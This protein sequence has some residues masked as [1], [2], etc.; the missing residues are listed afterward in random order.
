MLKSQNIFIILA[1][2]VLV[3]AKSVKKDYDEE[4]GRDYLKQI[5]AESAVKT[6]ESVIASW[7]YESNITDENL[8]HQVN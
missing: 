4:A 6:T 7:G 8:Q 2:A 3:T 5:N 1:L